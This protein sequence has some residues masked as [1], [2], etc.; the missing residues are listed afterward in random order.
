MSRMWGGGGFCQQCV[1][2]KPYKC[3]DCGK[4][5]RQKT[6]LNKHARIHTS[7]NH[8]NIMIVEI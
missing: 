7:E 5:F 2:E 3:K 6:H 1:G 4:Q 8:S